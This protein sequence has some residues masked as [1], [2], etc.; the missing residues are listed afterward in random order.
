MTTLVM[1]GNYAATVA[2]LGEG[3]VIVTDDTLPGVHSLVGFIFTAQCT[4][5]RLH[6]L[7]QT[8]QTQLDSGTLT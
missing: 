3:S 1:N 4:P 6:P 8:I 2:P 5:P 7:A